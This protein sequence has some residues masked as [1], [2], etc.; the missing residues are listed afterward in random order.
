[1]TRSLCCKLAL[2]GLV[3]LVIV[4]VGIGFASVALSDQC[5]SS[6]GDAGDAIKVEDEDEDD[7]DASNSTCWPEV[8][9]TAWL[10][11]TLVIPL[12]LL[13]AL[14]LCIL[15][16]LICIKIWRDDKADEGQQ[17]EQPEPT[18]CGEYEMVEDM[19]S[20]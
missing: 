18:R 3:A 8:V 20:P 7:S 15:V 12:L 11:M 17:A 14:M 1:M 10:L 4:W 13:L 2:S 16:G 5:Q 19:P 9:A 6:K